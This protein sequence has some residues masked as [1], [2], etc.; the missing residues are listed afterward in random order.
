M[1][2]FSALLAFCARNSPVTGDFPSQKASDTEVWYF[3][4]S[5]SEQTTKQAVEKQV[6]WEAIAVI[7]TSL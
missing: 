7:V 4:W 2:A 6:I 5:A 1:K 3:F